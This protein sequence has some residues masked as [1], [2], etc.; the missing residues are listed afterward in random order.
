VTSR[1]PLAM[2]LVAA[3]GLL[4]AASAVVPIR[5]DLGDLLP[6]GGSPAARLL[7]RELRDGAAA[8][9]IL[10]A[11]EGGNED[12]LASVSNRLVRALAADSRIVFADNG[13]RSADQRW[14]DALFAHRYLL[15][16]AVDTAAFSV[17]Q[18][19]TGFQKLLAGLQS[20]ASP[21]VQQYGLP[22]PTGAFPALLRGWTANSRVRMAQGVWFAAGAPPRALMVIR[23]AAAGAG[24][25]GDGPAITAIENAFATARGDTSARL[26]LAGPPVFARDVAEGIQ[27][28][29]LRLT[30]LSGLLVVGLL[31][32]RFRSPWVLAA[33]AIP[34]LLGVAAAMAVVA[35]RFGFVHGITLG[36]GMTM[37]GITVDYPVL[38]IGHRKHGEPAAGTWARIGPTYTLAVLT[39]AMGLTGMAFAGLSGVAQLGLFALVGVVTAALATRFL[40]PRLIVVARLSPVAFGDP[41]LVERVEAWRRFRGV[42]AAAVLIAGIYLAARGGPD[43]QNGLGSL[44][45]VPAEALALYSDL[46]TQLGAPEPGQIAVLRGQSAEAVLQAEEALQPRLDELTARGAIE[47]VDTAAWL[48]PSVARQSARQA[49]LP[50]ADTLRARVVQAADGLGFTATAFDRFEADVASARHMATV[51]PA[52]LAAAGLDSPELSA[53]LAALLVQRQDGWL[54]FIAPSGLRDPAAF[55]T[56]FRSRADAVFVDIGTETDALVAGYTRAVVRLL[57][58]GA[59][60]SVVALAVALRDPLHVARV[61]VAV[62]SALVVTVALLTAAG[63]RLSLVHLVALPFVAGV[64]CDYALFFGRRQVDTEERARTLRT[65]LICVTMAL[66]TFGL[67]ATCRTPLLRGIGETVAIGVCAA[68]SCGFLFAGPKAAA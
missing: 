35:L 61:L 32:W 52:G 42:G 48:I 56:L 20:S 4:A 18:L 27:T 31:I 15:S 57:L 62:A 24:L 53:R 67:L 14:I 30:V 68:I 58:A 2:W 39:A 37:L 43:W 10:A 19:R 29:V 66:L 21:L 54:G 49:A 51:R 47:G 40:L 65:L 26:L 60:V 12:A 22:D 64:G 9:V 38:F 33:I 63:A 41:A 23:L 5:S 7:L 45:P 25:G 55:A 16:P 17:P 46:Q 13:A 44:T 8:S 36:F 11:I 50:D 1:W 3:I 6:E 59:V 34:P 28:D